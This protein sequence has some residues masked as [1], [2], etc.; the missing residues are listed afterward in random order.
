[1]P[2]GTLAKLIYEIWNTKI[3]NNSD[4]NNTKSLDKAQKFK[5]KH[6]SFKQ[7]QEQTKHKYKYNELS[8][9]TN[10]I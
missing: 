1:M 10:R 6:V 7:T 5:D 8:T 4:P 9:T 2:F 3:L